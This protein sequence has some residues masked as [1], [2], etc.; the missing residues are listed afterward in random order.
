MFKDLW[1]VQE[2][3]T[4]AWKPTKLRKDDVMKKLITGKSSIKALQGDSDAQSRL[5]V[6]Y[7]RAVIGVFKYMQEDEVA[8]IFAK[9]KN[10]MGDIIGYLDKEVA[11]IPRQVVNQ[12]GIKVTYKPWVEDGLKIKWHKYMD[13]VFER[14]KDKGETFMNTWLDALDLEWNSQ[15][16]KD[17]FKINPKDDRAT[18]DKKAQIE[19]DYRAMLGLLRKTRTEWGNVKDW[20]KPANW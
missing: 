3:Q 19:K 15:K 16:K 9:E 2:D 12:Y 13:E 11:K 17:E 20:K 6:Q 10:R 14:A 5:A 1:N 7:L 4:A 18:R 8:E